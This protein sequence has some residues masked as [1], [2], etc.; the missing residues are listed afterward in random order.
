MECFDSFARRFGDWD[1]LLDVHDLLHAT[2]AEIG[3]TVAR[4]PRLPLV[5]ADGRALQDALR[6]R[7]RRLVSFQ[8]AARRHAL[9]VTAAI[10]PGMPSVL[11]LQ[12]KLGMR[13]CELVL[14]LAGL[15]ALY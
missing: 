14:P 4:D 11:A 13:R 5:V 1:D 15:G 6:Q 3:I 10:P 2:A 7:L 8:P 9:R 12:L